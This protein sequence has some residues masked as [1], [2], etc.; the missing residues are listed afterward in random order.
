MSIR[1]KILNAFVTLEMRDIYVV[2]LELNKKQYKE[3]KVSEK[4]KADVFGGAKIE[5][6]NELKNPV[7]IGSDG[8]KAIYKNKKWF[9]IKPEANKDFSHVIIG[10]GILGKNDRIQTTNKATVQGKLENIAEVFLNRQHKIR[11]SN[12]KV[13]YTT[14]GFYNLPIIQF[15]GDILNLRKRLHEH[16]DMI[17]NA[18]EK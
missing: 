3:L 13:D 1:D 10:L 18:A 15:K 9:L 12:G 7:A 14:R 4:L 16:I 2:A 5:I 11:Y 6:N 17:C 8:S